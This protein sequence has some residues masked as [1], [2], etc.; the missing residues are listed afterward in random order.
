VLDDIDF[1]TDDRAKPSAKKLL[2][3]WRPSA[4]ESEDE[5]KAETANGALE[6]KAVS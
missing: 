3:K 4:L 2:S 6:V 1:V 5:T